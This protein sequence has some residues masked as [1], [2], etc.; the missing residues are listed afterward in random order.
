MNSK[1]ILT[2]LAYR[3]HG[4]KWDDISI[5]MN[6]PKRTMQRIHKKYFDEFIGPQPTRSI[7]TLHWEDAIYFRMQVNRQKESKNSYQERFKARFCLPDGKKH[8]PSEMALE[9]Q[10]EWQEKHHK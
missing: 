6:S 7:P 5:V 2:L 4:F 3:F 10:K 9:Y 8:Q 1:D